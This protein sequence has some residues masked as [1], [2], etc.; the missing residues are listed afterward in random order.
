MKET[1]LIREIPEQERP[2][3]KFYQYGVGALSDA[4]LL[5]IILR[6]GSHKKGVLELAREVLDSS[7]VEKGIIGLN[8]LTSQELSQVDGIGPVKAAQI[9]CVAEIAKR[10]AQRTR[11]KGL[12]FHSPE[13]VANYYM[14][15]LRFGTNEVLLL[16]MLNNKNILIKEMT[17]STG[18]VNASVADPREIF[19]Q[20]LKYQ[21]VYIILLHNHPS[22]DPTPSRD[23]I[24]VTEQIREAG[25][26]IGISL[27]DHIII[28]DNTYISLREQ[29]YI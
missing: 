3:E 28:G 13:L 23:D 5:A 1:L 20:A 2:Y 8:Y 4:E 11:Q 18:T 10:M 17:L 29:G 25:Q 19:L 9:L 14:P 22:G 15:R 6:T 26:L 12:A 24:R 7:V 27:N 16:L 21:A